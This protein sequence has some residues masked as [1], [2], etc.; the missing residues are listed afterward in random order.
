MR[1]SG[2][3]P[4]IAKPSRWT[5]LETT[6]CWWLL[7]TVLAGMGLSTAFGLWWADPVAALTIP[8]LLLREAREAWNSEECDD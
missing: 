5:C 1:S 4:T 2:C 7:L 8:V 3:S 6:A